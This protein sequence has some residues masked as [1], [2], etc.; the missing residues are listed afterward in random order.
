ML[1]LI[2]PKLF[3]IV[4]LNSNMRLEF[5]KFTAGDIEEKEVI[6]TTHEIKDGLLRRSEELL[7]ITRMLHDND[8]FTRACQDL[9]SG[10]RQQASRIS[11]GL[12]SPVNVNEVSEGI[13]QI[14][15]KLL[16]L[17]S[18]LCSHYD[19]IAANKER[20]Q[21]M[22]KCYE[23]ALHSLRKHPPPIFEEH[24]EEYKN[25]IEGIDIVYSEDER[26]ERGL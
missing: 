15:S 18:R 12:S 10:I 1:T 24:I 11:N 2:L 25:V 5:E 20:E 23:K 22:A 6:Q 26:A 17:E 16:T 14:D 9:S 3:E 8:E 7:E 4:S 21:I 19:E 13:R